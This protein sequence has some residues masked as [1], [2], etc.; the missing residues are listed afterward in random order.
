MCITS[1]LHKKKQIDEYVQNFYGSLFS[2]CVHMPQSSSENNLQG[3]I[4]T[5]HPMTLG[6]WTR[7]TG[8]G[9]EY[10]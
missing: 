5:F 6:D 9:G 1:L 2:L 4:F 7:I 8:L 3:S 10:L